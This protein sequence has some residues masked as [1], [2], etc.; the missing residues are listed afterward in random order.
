[1]VIQCL[2]KLYA[3]HAKAIGPFTDVLILV[4]TMSSTK[5]TETQHRLLRLLATVL[6]NGQTG[7]SK[8]DVPENAEQLLNTESINQL[9]QFVAW[10][11]TDRSQI[12]NIL[13]RSLSAVASKASMITDGTGKGPLGDNKATAATTNDSVCPAVWF[14]ASSSKV[15]PKPEL[16]RGPFRLSELVQMMEDGNIGPYDVVTT[17]HTEEYDVEDGGSDVVKEAQIDTGKWKRLNQVWQLRWTLCSDPSGSLILSPSDVSLLA[18]K[19]LTRLVDLHKSFDS[20]G[21]PYFPIPIAKRI[22]SSAQNSS[23]SLT[24]G[25]PLSLL[26]QAILCN[27]ADVVQH[28]ADLVRKVSL[29]NEEATPKLY[30]TGV[31]YFA[32]CY[33]GSNFLS[34]ARLLY[35]THLSQQF[36]SGFSAAAN[37]SEI[38]MKERSFLGN[39]IPEGLL[40]ILVNYGPERFADIFV[41]SADTP[42]VIWTFEM[43]KHLIEMVHQ[44]LGDFPLRLFQNNT[45][46]YQ[47]CPIPGVSYKRLDKELFCHN[48]YLH[49][50]CDEAKFPDWP[51]AEPVEVF[52]ACLEL[53]RKELEEDTTDVAAELESARQVL[54]LEV[55]NDSKDLRKAYRRLARMFHPDKNPSGREKFETIQASYE[56]LLPILEGGEK[57]RVFSS[58]AK[59]DGADSV[60]DWALGN[61]QMETMELLVQTQLLICRRYE[62]EMSRYK[63]PGYPV[64]LG[65]VSLPSNCRQMVEAKEYDDILSTSVLRSDV[66]CFLRKAMELVYRTCLVSPLNAAELVAEGGVQ[67]LVSL[68]SFFTEAILESNKASG[69]HVNIASA[70]DMRSIILYTVRTLAGTAFY[71]SGRNAISSV[72][73]LEQV[74]FDLCRCLDGSLCA[75]SVPS[76]EEIHIK[77]FS[78]DCIANMA[79]DATLQD[80]IIRCGAVWPIVRTALSFDPTLEAQS[81]NN[82]DNIGFSAAS[83]NASARQAVRALAMLSGAQKDAPSHTKMFN[84]MKR[85]LSDPIALMLRHSR[86]D[87]ILRVLNSSVETADVIWNASMRK[88]LDSYVTGIHS[89][90]ERNKVLSIKDELEPCA[91]FEYDSLKDELVVGG[92]YVRLFNKHGKD[93][94]GR[95]QNPSAFCC[96]LI[97]FIAVNMN[98]SSDSL[99]SNWVPMPL[100]AS[101]VDEHSRAPVG[102]SFFL[103]AIRALLILCRVDGL[104]DGV[105]KESE[106]DVSTVLL[107]FLELDSEVSISAACLSCFIY[108]Y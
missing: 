40:Y 10:G 68:L 21:V 30:L 25:K 37:E 17:S 97:D 13:S 87:E 104:M 12:G 91:R 7:T 15:P 72:V 22:L 11:H 45:A 88:Q 85:I 79:S 106:I 47:Y 4:Q 96:S 41:G 52:R 36:R 43:R 73:H 77:R 80:I 2:E 51:I 19:A 94:L 42:E 48:Y 75:R 59:Q 16:V 67:L 65:C 76:D 56:L 55:G 31:F 103:L 5:S 8:V 93:S 24:A 105:I 107:S 74:V 89:K 82:S 9:C 92:I 99:G 26:S 86:P 39:I 100:P 33:T 57:V 81:H 69:E 3:V 53:F 102:S 34:L 23:G 44:H 70:N 35:Q 18:L 28:A 58:E 29:H 49:N 27:H 20:R 63:Y 84:A 54:E 61:A 14:V 98:A 62:A 38:P 1:M 90:R 32:C 60:N 108:C 95:I 50:L 66:S 78:I 101:L 64:L 46:E 83:A 71:E 6:G